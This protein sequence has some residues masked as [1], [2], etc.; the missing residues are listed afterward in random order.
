[1]LV[2]IHLKR[3][4]VNKKSTERETQVPKYIS[5]HDD[6]YLWETCYASQHS[7]DPEHVDSPWQ[8]RYNCLQ[9]I[10]QMSELFKVLPSTKSH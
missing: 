1:M 4:K 3:K 8:L 7:K 6:K 2:C 10:T 5:S 9:Q